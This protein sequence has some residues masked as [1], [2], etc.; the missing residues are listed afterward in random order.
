M[1]HE[2]EILFSFT[3]V[4]PLPMDK[5]IQHTSVLILHKH[6]SCLGRWTTQVCGV[7]LVEVI[8]NLQASYAFSVFH[9]QFLKVTLA[10]STFATSASEH[11]LLRNFPEVPLHHAS[12]PPFVQ[13]LCSVL[14]FQVKRAKIA[15][16]GLHSLSISSFPIKAN[17]IAYE[18]DGVAINI[19]V[20][21]FS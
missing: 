5:T 14:N 2:C 18:S 15:Y 10:S 13:N 20:S 8:T 21:H 12:S 3:W 6:T 17:C 1:G 4:L 11:C 9:H 19:L 7:F 16:G